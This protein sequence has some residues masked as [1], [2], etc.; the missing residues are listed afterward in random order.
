MQSFNDLPEAAVA[1][2]YLTLLIQAVRYFQRTER[3][4]FSTVAASFGALT[5]PLATLLA[6]ATWKVD[7]VVDAAPAMVL[8]WIASTIAFC[9]SELPAKAPKLQ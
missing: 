7:A 5:L 2:A 8:S 1:L 3:G 6:L 4:L 9:R